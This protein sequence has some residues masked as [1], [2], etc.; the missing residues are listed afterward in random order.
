ML[1]V[2]EEDVEPGRLEEHQTGLDRRCA[3]YYV[4]AVRVV[5]R[6]KA[7][8][9]QP[10]RLFLGQPVGSDSPLY[11]MACRR[12]FCPGFTPGAQLGGSLRIHPQE[13]RTDLAWTIGAAAMTCRPEH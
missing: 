12:D 4:C 6:H 2:G 8:M 3:A 13:L 7:H 10:R 11:D 1:Y 9:A 5:S